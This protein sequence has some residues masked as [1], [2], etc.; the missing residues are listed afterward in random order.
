MLK[1]L[2]GSPA[3]GTERWEVTVEPGRVSGQVAFSR[4][5]LV[6]PACQELGKTHERMG[7]QSGR[8]GVVVGRGGQG[9]PL[10]E[11]D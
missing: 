1:G 9:G 11:E 4:S 2:G 10:A 6:N 7:G 3:P 5:H 8:E